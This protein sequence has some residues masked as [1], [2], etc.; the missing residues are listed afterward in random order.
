MG[1]AR[2]TTER[3]ISWH[4]FLPLAGHAVGRFRARLRDPRFW[5]VQGL[6][7][8]AT[9]I[10]WGVEVFEVLTDHN[11]GIFI[12][13]MYA[14]YFVPV[15]Y[16][17]LNFG[18]DGAIPTAIWA[19]FL[20]LPPTF[21]WHHGMERVIDVLQH[22]TI[23]ALAVVIA[24]RVD[25]EVAAR[26]ETEREIVGRRISEA[27]YRG[28]FEAASEAIILFDRAGVVQEANVAA[29]NLFRREADR[30]INGRLS[31][32]L[33]DDNATYLL[34]VA[35]GEQVMSRDLHM[36]RETGDEIWL[37]PTCSF[38]RTNGDPELVQ[39]L[40][41][42]VTEQRTRQRGLETYAQQII[43]AQEE[44]RRR[45]ARD[46]HDGALQS[47]VLL[48]R[49]LDALETERADSLEA[50]TEGV[51]R[52]RHS[53]KAIADDLRRFSRNLRPSI[54]DDLGLVPAVRWLVN[55]LKLR[56]GLSGT[57]VVNGERRSLSSDEELGLFRIAQEALHNVE[58]HA[59][60]SSITVSLDYA[61][62]KVVL[63]VE[64]DGIGIAMAD[65]IPTSAAS[66]NLGLL[67]MQERARLLGGTFEITSSIGHGTCIHVALP[68]GTLKEE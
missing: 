68:T 23:I 63:S 13:L 29:L 67:G 22:L 20:A 62:G 10:H 65:P 35:Q 15:I 45:I 59:D 38:V 16:A 54:L 14:V 55:D 39:V 19:A 12:V 48:Y 26:R 25:R 66:G 11:V 47:V 27:K 42:D 36:V 51:N 24:T 9:A 32:L 6:V 28:L 57:L 30:V 34:Q 3:I 44:E 60:A 50:L 40:F 31:G 49:Q 43:R 61:D 4:S 5:A 1:S 41:R 53:T 18:R 64:D 46:L 33:G 58:R 52:V 8:L 7:V 17:S 21:L 56:T 37:E 2:L